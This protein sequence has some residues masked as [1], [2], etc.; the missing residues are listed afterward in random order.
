MPFS[1]GN[2]GSNAFTLLVVGFVFWIIYIKVTG[3]SINWAYI[4]HR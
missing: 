3:K 1:W 2:V 4:F